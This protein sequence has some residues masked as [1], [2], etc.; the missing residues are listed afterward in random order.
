MSKVP[1][2]LKI[3]TPNQ[4]KLKN[5]LR[6]MESLG[7][8]TIC[9]SAKCP[10]AGECFAEDTAT[11]LIL[12]PN[13]SR[14]CRFC[15]VGHGPLAGVDPEEPPKVAQAVAKLG[16]KYVVITSVTRDDLPDYGAD[17]FKAVITKIKENDPAMRVEVLIP[18]LMGDEQALA[19]IV[20]AGPDVIGHNLETVPRLYPKVLPKSFYGRSLRIL[21][22]VKE[23]RP[24]LVTKSSLMVGLGEAEAE[25]DEVFHDLQ[26]VGCDIL[27]LGQYLQPTPQQLPIERYVDQEE[28]SRYREKAL[29]AGIRK[30]YGGPLVRSSYHARE[31]FQNLS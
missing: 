3:G 10:N 1:Q 29:A 8:N 16:L 13:C 7:V 17:Q 18:D 28:F 22:A 14:S 31:V 12:G 24:S 27:T 15:A 19:A 21:Q 9:T 23:I 4:E 20:Q 30:V 26:G 25:L 5:M 6:L 11:F 2:W